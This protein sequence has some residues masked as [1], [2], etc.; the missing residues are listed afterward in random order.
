[1]THLSGPDLSYAGVGIV[2][3]SCLSRVIAKAMA[4]AFAA[5]LVVYIGALAVSLV[6]SAIFLCLSPAVAFA[7]GH[8]LATAPYVFNL[9][10]CDRL[11]LA[12][13]LWHRRVALPFIAR[14]GCLPI[15]ALYCLSHSAWMYFG[16]FMG[17]AVVAAG[18]YIPGRLPFSTFFICSVAGQLGCSFLYD[19]SVLQAMQLGCPLLHVA[20]D[21]CLLPAHQGTKHPLSVDSVGFLRS[22]VVPPTPLRIVG[23]LLVVAAPVAF[24]RSTAQRAAVTVSTLETVVGEKRQLLSSPMSSPACSS[25]QLVGRVPT[26]R[27]NTAP[28]DSTCSSCGAVAHRDSSTCSMPLSPETV[29][30]AEVAEPLPV[31][32]DNTSFVV[33][34]SG[35]GGLTDLR[36]TT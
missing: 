20:A 23:L 31:L 10:V 25:T 30:A 4:S 14:F 9:A 16:G 2:L 27:R 19:R 6:V 17:V 12:F 22:T 11:V 35:F 13:A 8:Q 24:Q 1:M 3:V 7:L 21:T 29:A 26:L 32:S 36:N 33:T 18:A 5:T 15:A 28:P 34:H